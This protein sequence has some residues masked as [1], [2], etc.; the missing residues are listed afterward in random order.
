MTE[1]W[2]PAG[3]KGGG[4]SPEAALGVIST[5]SMTARSHGGHQLLRASWACVPGGGLLHGWPRAAPCSRRRPW[6][7]AVGGVPQHVKRGGVVHRGHHGQRLLSCLAV[8]LGRH[9]VQLQHGCY[10]L[11]QQAEGG[12]HGWSRHARD[13]AMLHRGTSSGG[14]DGSAAAPGAAQAVP[15][16]RPAPPLARRLTMAEPIA[17]MPCR[18]CS[19]QAGPKGKP[20]I[21]DTGRDSLKRH[22]L[23][24]FRC[25][26]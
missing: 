1:S 11:R 24:A 7:A 15:P 12:E 2:R 25:G 16:T 13:T 26:S 14:M 23:R 17:G 19:G 18:P 4:R 6:P 20:A 3:R 5:T 21:L 10:R 8:L 22:A 9:A